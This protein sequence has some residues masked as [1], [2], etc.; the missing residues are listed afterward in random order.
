MD[1]YDHDKYKCIDDPG[2]VLNLEDARP[3]ER[4]AAATNPKREGGEHGATVDPFVTEEDINSL[5]FS[6]VIDDNGLSIL[7][8]PLVTDEEN[9]Y[10]STYSLGI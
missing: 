5:P 6:L 10:C 3:D 4:G 2:A 9:P 1:K 7:A 8:R